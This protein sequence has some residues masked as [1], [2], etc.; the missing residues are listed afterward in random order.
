[1]RGA[2]TAGVVLLIA[3][4]AGAALAQQPK[5][6]PPGPPPSVSPD[7]PAPPPDISEEASAAPA[8]VL[9]NEQVWN[10][11][12]K[13]AVVFG[14]DIEN[15]LA[16]RKRVRINNEAG[17]A[18]ANQ[19]IVSF[20]EPRNVEWR[21]TRFAARTV[22]PDGSKVEVT[23][24]MRHD[25]VHSVGDVKVHELQFTFPAVRPGAVL[26][27][28]YE[29]HRGIL[30]QWPLWDVQ[31]SIP[32]LEA[33]FEARRS[34]AAQF[35]A[36]A[37]S[38]SGLAPYCDVESL[39]PEGDDDI[40]RV[41][42]RNVPAYAREPLS[43][44]EADARLRMFV[45][46][47]DAFRR[48]ATS[49]SDE[50][51]GRYFYF[52]AK[53]GK[54]KTLAKELFAK[55]TVDE[56]LAKIGAWV[57]ANIVVADDFSRYGRE[58]GPNSSV[59]ELLEKKIGTSVEAAMLVHVLAQEAG[60]RAFLLWGRDVSAQACYLP[61]PERSL[62]ERIFV[63]VVD[64]RRTLHV[65]PAC[66]RC[67]PGFAE[68]RFC[69]APDSG[70]RI[71]GDD[72]LHT[73][74]YGGAIA[75]FPCAPADRNVLSRR[76]RIELAADGKGKVAGEATWG[77][78]PEQELR[79]AWA[80]AKAERRAEE[81]LKD[82]P[83]ALSEAKV[84][85]GDVNDLSV[86]YAVKYAFAQ[87]DAAL[88]SGGKLVVRPRDVVAKR[89]GLPIDEERRFPLWWPRPFSVVVEETFVAPEGF[90]AGALPEA[91]KLSGP[92]LTFEGAWRVGSK[93]NELVYAAKVAVEKTKIPL[94]DYPAA[95]A[96]ALELRKALAAEATFEGK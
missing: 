53:R 83:G 77:G 41:T 33:R 74:S 42:C 91:K 56:R 1:M 2:K 11:M 92:G 47:Y 32:V 24:E 52:Q 4:A 72:K 54:T 71:L 80:D 14:R 69:G 64:G 37:H 40:V 60:L 76:E 7:Q 58:G 49:E 87:G 38:C 44:P 39:P 82:E 68:A 21:L 93:P 86:P 34:A 17:A 8:V 48:H 13:H 84:E 30:G 3:A 65:D 25:N 29:L 19:T 20:E 23:E 73:E 85:T 36:A 50:V 45:A 9:L 61:T 28:E 5:F 16:V 63:E 27:W 78:Q 10:V 95:R 94:K 26:E 6:R 75:N 66:R 88:A 70:F 31:E 51:N 46:P 81:F 59:D 15:T 96:F 12:A 55:G 90:K 79:D 89:L 67:R 22:L 57:R 18:Q 62:D 43:P 35:G